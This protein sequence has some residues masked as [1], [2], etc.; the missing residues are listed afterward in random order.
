MAE[1]LPAAK[2]HKVETGTER[3]WK[4]RILVAGGCGFIGASL[5]TRLVK[6]GHDVI[7]E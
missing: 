1:V 7:C 3:I 5:C 4:K 2:R 6:E